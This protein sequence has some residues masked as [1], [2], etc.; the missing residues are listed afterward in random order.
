MPSTARIEVSAKAIF[1]VASNMVEEHTGRKLKEDEVA[2]MVA[3]CVRAASQSVCLDDL[4]RELMEMRGFFEE[5][6]QWGS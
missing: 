5:V 3:Q 6:R 2:P 4:R 1:R